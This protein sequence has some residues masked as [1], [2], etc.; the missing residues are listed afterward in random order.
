MCDAIHIYEG[1]QRGRFPECFNYY[2]IRQKRAMSP[3]P[4]PPYFCIGESVH[5]VLL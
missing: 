4:P 2:D 3:S 1:V 5:Q